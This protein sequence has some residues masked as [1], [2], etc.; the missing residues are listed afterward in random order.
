[1]GSCRALGAESQCFKAASRLG[2]DGGDGP[3]QREC[4]SFHRTAHGK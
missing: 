4:T 2:V 1:M 3:Q